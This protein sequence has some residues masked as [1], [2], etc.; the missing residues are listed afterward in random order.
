MR[1]HWELTHLNWQSCPVRC[2][3]LQYSAVQYSTSQASLGSCNT[4]LICVSI[5]DTPNPS[6]SQYRPHCPGLHPVIYGY[7][8]TDLGRMG[9]RCMPRVTAVSSLSI[10]VERKVKL[11]WW[12][13][14]EL[15][16]TWRVD[17][18]HVLLDKTWQI[19]LS[20]SSTSPPTDVQSAAV[21]V[22][23]A[24]L[25]DKSFKEL[26]GWHDSP[27]KYPSIL[28]NLCASSSRYVQKQRN[29]VLVQIQLLS[30]K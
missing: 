7:T 17:C 26:S 10:T 21:D 29:L 9:P 22:N 15:K 14:G 2:P 30:Y 25:R 1:C 18:C 19:F 4:L 11:P 5:S 28:N 6:W 23:T 20:K 8:R 12:S 16:W 3:H 24:R 27:D 13:G